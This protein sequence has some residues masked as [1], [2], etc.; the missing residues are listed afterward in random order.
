MLLSLLSVPSKARSSK[1]CF[2]ALCQNISISPNAKDLEL[3]L[4][5]L[6]S[7]SEFVRATILEAID[8]EFELSP[9]M[10]F[11][12]QIFILMQDASES[13]RDTASFIWQFNKFEV[14]EELM[15]SLLNFFAQTDSGLRLFVARAYANALRILTAKSEGFFEKYLGVLMDFYSSKARVPDPIVDEYGLVVMSSEAQKDHWEERSTAQ[16][17]LKSFLHFI[18]RTVNAR[19]SLL[20]SW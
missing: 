3:I 12:P 11:S 9:Y 14:N 13:N 4:G 7:S 19:S 1:E 10:K 2:L 5:T 15:T 8:D 16:L 18:R 20:S 6:M 17:R